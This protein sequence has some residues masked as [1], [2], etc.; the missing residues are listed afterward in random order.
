MGR[1]VLITGGARSGKSTFAEKIVSDWSVNGDGSNWQAGQLEPSPTPQNVLYVAT[2]VA[3]DEEMKDRIRKHK[4]GRPNTWETLEKYK[5]FGELE[6]ITEF[7]SAE[8]ILLDCLGVMLN[9][10]IFDEKGFDPDTCSL[11]QIEVIENKM[12]AEVDALIG[13]AKTKKMVVV[14]N[15]VGLSIVPENRLARFYRD[16]LG[17][18]NR[19]VAE[20]ADDVHFVVSGIPMKIK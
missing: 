17:R 2:A 15:E 7:Q 11:G 4:E 1:L 16:I 10:I 13:A 9:N 5:K 6:H 8:I 12:L 18:T 3:F 14:T 19:H 20:N